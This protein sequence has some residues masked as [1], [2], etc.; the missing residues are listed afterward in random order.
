MSFSISDQLTK[1]VQTLTPPPAVLDADYDG[2]EYD[3]KYLVFR[4]ALFKNE[5]FLLAGVA[6][7]LLFFWFGKRSNWNKTNSWLNA[8]LPLYEK[9]FSAP[10]NGGLTAD[11]YSDFFNFSTGRRV[12]ASLHTVFTLRPR[13]DLLQMIYQF[14]WGLSDLTYAPQDE[15]ELDFKLHSN[16]TVPDFIWAIV[17][18][19]ELRS[20]KSDRWDLTWTRTTDHPSLTGPLSVMSEFAD[21]TENILKVSGPVLQALKDP[22]VLVHF[23]SLSITDQPR[24]RPDKASYPRSKHV[25]LSL[26]APSPSRAADTLPL[27]TAVFGSS[28]RSKRSTTPRDQVEAAQGAG[29]VRRRGERVSGE[30]KARGVLTVSSLQA[31]DAKQAAKKKAE[32]ERIAKLSAAEQQKILER[33]RKR[34]MRKT[35]GKM[36]VKK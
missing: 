9:Q 33:D 28:T 29:R 20:I 23:K 30:G 11:G 21:V 27:V 22:K 7:H 18:K 25:I 12:V 13:H 19:E 3:F 2:L 15:I 1:L 5:A 24:D 16:T 8:H 17:A 34:A 35:Q 36:S 6:V 4:P 31:A 10:T 14:I 26:K 32:E